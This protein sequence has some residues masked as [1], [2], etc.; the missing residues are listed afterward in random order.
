MKINDIEFSNEYPMV[1]HKFIDSTLY[2]TL[3]KLKKKIDKI[4][5]ENKLHI[6]Y[7]FLKISNPYEYTP[8][9]DID[10]RISRS[11]YKL[12]EI[13]K[14]FNIIKTNNKIITGHLCESPGGFIECVLFKNNNAVCLAQSLKDSN[15][16]FSDIFENKINITYGEDN[17]G[18]LFKEI[19]INDFI[20]QSIK[21]G[22][23]DLI[24][25][26][27]GFDVSNDYLKQEQISFRLIYCQVIT[28]IGSLK[29]NGNF[30]CKLFDIYTLPTVQ[31]IYL[32]K[33]SFEYIHIYKPLM[34]RPC[35]SEKYII[36]MNFKGINDDIF[37]KLINIVNKFE[38]KQNKIQDL[39]ID[40]PNI[41]IDYLYKINNEFIKKQIE[42][43]TKVFN[44]YEIESKQKINLI[45]KNSLDMSYNYIKYIYQP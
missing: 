26:D 11:F 45:K 29:L 40:L 31:L 38:N 43:L 17:T 14:K 36:C 13:N 19:N 37:N 41:F 32:L 1:N 33:Q 15:C 25:A 16:Q 9:L 23:C 6:W 35:N 4:N 22:K 34:S 2:F 3:V 10:K 20:N 5:F 18:D 8:Q 24:T 44:V 28:A 12:L 27:G 30:V 42:S 21:L 39:D 7:K